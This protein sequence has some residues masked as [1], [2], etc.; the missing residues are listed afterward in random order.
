MS[1]A[2]MAAVFI[3]AAGVD[4]HADITHQAARVATHH[5]KAVGQCEDA[6]CLI[7]RLSIFPIFRVQN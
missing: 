5:A 3:A 7:H 1:Q 4:G 2:V 6:V